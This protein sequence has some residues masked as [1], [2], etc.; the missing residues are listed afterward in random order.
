MKR[1]FK[2]I[3]EKI[4]KHSW[5]R[6]N[7][8]QSVAEIVG[9]FIVLSVVLIIFYRIQR[10]PVHKEIITIE[11]LSAE[12]GSV[13]TAINAHVKYKIPVS[14]ALEESIRY[15]SL[16]IDFDF[17]G[18][19]HIVANGQEQVELYNKYIKYTGIEPITRGRDSLLFASTHLENSAILLSLNSDKRPV[20]ED[21]GVVHYLHK[22]KDG[23]IEAEWYSPY[24]PPKK[25]DYLP[26]KDGM[27]IFGLSPTASILTTAP[28]S[29]PSW[30]S[31]YDVSQSYYEIQ[32]KGNLTVDSLSFDFIGAIDCSKMSPEPDDVTMNSICFVRHDKIQQIKDYGLKYHVKYLEMERNQTIRV[33]LVSA[34]LSA[35]FAIFIA[36]S[37]F[38]LCVALRKIIRKSHDFRK[39][40]YDGLKNEEGDD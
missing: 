3:K 11:R 27:P 28:Y 2:K 6:N 30:W 32:L 13:P 20:L 38:C 9:Y 14:Y 33:F 15:G 8:I 22:T 10:I 21:N 16:I 36:V 7:N 25:D 1:L 4:R 34:I 24:Y 37:V 26:K 31:L 40:K 23:S 35:L 39:K 29:M 5:P 18:P 17:E 12:L 19:T